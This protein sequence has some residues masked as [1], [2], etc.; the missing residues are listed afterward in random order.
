MTKEQILA[1]Q[2]PISLKRYTAAFAPYTITILR[3]LVGFTFLM[4]GLPK[5]PGLGAFTAYLPEAASAT[6]RSVFLPVPGRAP[7]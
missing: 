3:V 2:E 5:I 1:S 6:A 4:H 7:P